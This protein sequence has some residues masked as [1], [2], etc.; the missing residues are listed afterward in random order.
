MITQVAENIYTAAYSDL[1]GQAAPLF[2]RNQVIDVRH[3]VDRAGNGIESIVESIDQAFKI[4]NRENEVVIACDM[5]ISRSRVVAIGLLTRLGHSVSSAISQVLVATGSPEINPDLLHQLR[6]HFEEEDVRAARAATHGRRLV[7]LGDDEQFAATLKESLSAQLAD[8]EIPFRCNWESE[9]GASGLAARFRSGGIECVILCGQERSHHSSKG[10]AST[11]KTLKDVLDAC[12]LAGSSL[13]YL[14]NMEA[15]QGLAFR[16]DKVNFPVTDDC[17]PFP[18]G[19]YSET[20]YLCENLIDAYREA[21]LLNVSILRASRIYGPGMGEHWL[22]PK[23]ILKSLDNERIITHA[24]SN[25]LPEL[26]LLHIMDFCNAVRLVVGEG[27]QNRNLNVGSRDL[28][29]TAELAASII[30][31]SGSRSTHDLLQLSDATRNVVSCPG[32]LE[33]MGWRAT[34][35][36]EEGLSA[37][38]NSIK[39][40]RKR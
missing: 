40:D 33:R 10:M 27:M 7:I 9:G 19:T 8:I 29:S 16:Q 11:L 20:M 23:L 28:T 14:S 5:G 4:Y 1:G 6:L 22:I 24:F 25:G 18:R 13:L 36:L 3:L 21:Y 17:L 34:V 31:L 32:H 26:E 30:R 39:N 37:C 38:I 15:Y 2:S 12:R 35:N